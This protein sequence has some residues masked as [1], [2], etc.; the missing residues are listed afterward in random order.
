MTEEKKKKKKTYL[1]TL[2]TC[3]KSLAEG[4]CGEHGWSF[5]AIPVLLGEGIHTTNK[6]RKERLETGAVLRNRRK[7]QQRK[8]TREEK[9]EREREAPGQNRVLRTYIFF[10]PPFFPLEIRLFFPTAMVNSRY[11]VP[12]YD[13]S[14]SLTLSSTSASLSLSPA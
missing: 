11:V 10:F 12:V 2:S 1:G 6:Q 4:S 3:N 5:K 8:E 14:K 7:K 13:S 9:K